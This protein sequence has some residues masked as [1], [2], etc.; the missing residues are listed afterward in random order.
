[1][2]LTPG[3]IVRYSRE[4]GSPQH[5]A[6]F[7]LGQPLVIEDVTDTDCL[8]RFAYNVTRFRIPVG[9]VGPFPPGMSAS[10]AA[11]EALEPVKG[12]LAEVHHEQMMSAYKM[13]VGSGKIPK[14]AERRIVREG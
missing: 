1:M 12:R 11:M 2:K 10:E 4:R 3:D 8:A 7:P 5:P 13:L 6:L 9:D 14:I